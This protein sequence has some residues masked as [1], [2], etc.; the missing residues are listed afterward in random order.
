MCQPSEKPRRS[1]PQAPQRGAELCSWMGLQ[2]SR[3]SLWYLKCHFRS[4]FVFVMQ[5][6]CY[7]CLHFGEVL[8]K[9]S[10]LSLFLRKA[11]SVQRHLVHRCPVDS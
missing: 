9:N 10:K 1:S 4:S 5:P 7:L 8:V 2:I 3:Q 11:L 6:A